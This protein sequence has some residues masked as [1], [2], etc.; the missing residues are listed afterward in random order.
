MATK[1]G[2]LRVAKMAEM[3]EVEL[4]KRSAGRKVKRM[5]WL[6]ENKLGIELAETMDHM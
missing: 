5:G 1:S 4:G 6:K 2:K 3:M